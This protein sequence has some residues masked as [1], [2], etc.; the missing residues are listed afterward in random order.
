MLESKRS[1][2]QIMKDKNEMLPTIVANPK[3]ICEDSNVSLS[4]EDQVKYKYK[5]GM[6]QGK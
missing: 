5:T 2:L 3:I 1:T 4:T 6:F